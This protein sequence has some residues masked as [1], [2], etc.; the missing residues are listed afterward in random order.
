M[1]RTCAT[2][3]REL[4]VC[5]VWTR[6]SMLYS[7]ADGRFH[8]SLWAI[9]LRL[10]GPVLSMPDSPTLP[11]SPP[12]YAQTP[13][14]SLPTAF[15]M[16]TTPFRPV[17]HCGLCTSLRTPTRWRST[18]P[19]T[20]SAYHG[21]SNLLDYPRFLRQA[22]EREESELPEP[23]IESRD[24]IIMCSQNFPVRAFYEGNPKGVLF[25]SWD[26]L[27]HLLREKLGQEAT[28]AVFPCAAIQI[29]E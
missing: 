29:P 14:C 23:K 6:W 22:A 3:P 28:V 21:L 27:L 11:V 7:T 18:R 12:N 10:N 24:Q 26:T 25:R 2:L 8:G 13:T 15:R 4:P 20:V 9:S 16:I 17:S 5:S 1:S 19:R